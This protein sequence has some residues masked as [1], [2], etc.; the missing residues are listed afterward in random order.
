MARYNKN[1]GYIGAGLQQAKGTA[2]VPELFIPATDETSLS[3]T[4]EFDQQKELGDGIYPGTTV[5]TLHKMDGSFNANV[6][7]DLITFLF[8][9]FFGSDTIT[10][11]AAPYSHVI[12]PNA[13]PSGIP[14]LTLI[15]DVAGQIQEEFTDCRIKELT[16]AGEKGNRITVAVSVLGLTSEPATFTYSPTYETG[17]NMFMFYDGTYTKDSSAIG[18]VSAF[19]ITF[20]AEVVEDDQTTGIELADAPVTGFTIETTFTLDVDSTNA[21]EYDVVYYSGGAAS[22]S[23]DDGTLTLLF[24]NGLSTT[25]E[26]E[27]KIELHKLIYTAQPVETDASSKEQLQYEVTAHCEKHSSNGLAT[28][29]TKS[30]RATGPAATRATGTL[31]FTN[32]SADTQTVTIGTR[33]YEFTTDGV[34]AAGSHVAVDISGGASADLSVAGLAAAINAD[35]SSLVTA[36]ASTTADTVVVLSKIPGTVGNDYASTTTLANATWGAAKLA[37]GTNNG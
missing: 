1:S 29:T 15:R 17:A 14:W 21:A 6:K 28:I 5:K 22:T 19:S 2:V 26:R 35:T 30:A 4:M 11:S 24:N 20:K 25:N 7:A 32:V 36:I 18:T 9:A 12:I 23:L 16:I 10:G 13:T 31:T 8:D 27:L 3:P 37:G 33:V 34:L